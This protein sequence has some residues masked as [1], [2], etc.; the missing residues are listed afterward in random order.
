MPLVSISVKDLK[1]AGP[2]FVLCLLIS[3]AIWH[4]AVVEECR[5]APEPPKLQTVM[6]YARG[7]ANSKN[8]KR[9]M[10]I[11]AIRTAQAWMQVE[12]V[13][14]APWKPL[15]HSTASVDSRSCAWLHRCASTPPH[16]ALSLLPS[17]IDSVP[18]DLYHAMASEFNQAA[19]SCHLPLIEP[20]T[21]QQYFNHLS[22]CGARI[23]GDARIEPSMPVDRIEPR[24]PNV[25]NWFY[26]GAGVGSGICQVDE[27]G[28]KCLGVCEKDPYCQAVCS[29]TSHMPV[30]HHR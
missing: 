10:A 16:I 3:R 12:G 13:E 17:V 1:L 23:T 6:Y 2:L 15:P 18:T 29:D 25:Q 28:F 4:H 11:L 8:R 20:A 19:A 26:I 24:Q 21:L 30:F 14:A 7:Q 22:S 5:Q 9:R 27:L